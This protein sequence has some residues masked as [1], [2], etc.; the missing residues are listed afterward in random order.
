[1][2]LVDE[3]RRQLAWRYWHRA[4]SLCPLASG[5]K[6]LDLGCGPGD[7]SGMLAA[8][9]LVVTGVDENEELLAAARERY[10]ECRFERQDLRRLQVPRVLFDGL[11]CSFAAAYFVDFD[12]VWRSWATLLK[13]TGWACV[14]D[15]DDL[16][17]HEPI[18]APTRARIGSFYEDA[19]ERQRYDFRI[20]RKLCSAIGASGFQVAQFELDDSEFSF[21]GPAEPLVLDA[22]R[23]R[24][25]RLGGLRRFLGPDFADFRVEFL[26]CLASEAHRS[27]CRV[28]GCVGTRIGAS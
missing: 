15:I 26:G 3:Y 25:E 6:V 17:G 27:H 11:W 23:L 28:L 13:P 8:R 12:R 14:I 4:L 19:L 18:S 16:L 22:W 5:Q 20:G 1:M 7:V 9:G 2:T 10:P 24:F 21:Q